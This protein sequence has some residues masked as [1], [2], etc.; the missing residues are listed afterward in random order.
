[1]LRNLLSAELS[2]SAG[3]TPYCRRLFC[4]APFAAST[5][6]A[7][8]RYGAIYVMTMPSLCGQMCKY[9]GVVYGHRLGAKNP[10]IG[11]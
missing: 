7:M 11:T 8:V 5:R 2:L 4:F 9:D 1:M 10:D 6:F 3:F